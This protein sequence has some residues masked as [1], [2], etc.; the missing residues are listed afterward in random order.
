MLSVFAAV[1]TCDL[2]RLFIELNAESSAAH[3]TFA[4]CSS[5]DEMASSRSALVSISAD[6]D[7]PMS[8]ESDPASA[9][10]SGP[11][12]RDF[13]AAALAR[14]TSARV[15]VLFMDTATSVRS[16]NCRC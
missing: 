8:D 16:S 9:A 10:G 3:D 7:P 2:I 6:D 13:S 15:S 4:C 14:G 11:Q 5:E 12:V 1:I